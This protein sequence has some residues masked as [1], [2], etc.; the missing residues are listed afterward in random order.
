MLEWPP[1]RRLIAVRGELAAPGRPA[2]GFRPPQPPGRRRRRRTA[3]GGPTASRVR[4]GRRA[5]EGPGADPQAARARAARRPRAAGRRLDGV[6]DDDGRR[7]RPA[8]A[9][10]ARHAELGDR[11]PPRRAPRPPDRQHEPD[12]GQGGADRPRHEARDHRDRGQ[13]LLHQRRRRPP[14]HR[15][16]ALRGRRRPEGRPG[17]LDDRPAVR[18]E[19]AR[20]AGPPDAVREAA[21]G[22]A[23]VPHHAPLDQG[24][25]P[26]QLPQHDL[27]RQRRLR[28]RVRRPHLLR[29][30]A[31]GLREGP[32]APVRRP[33]RAG[34]GRDDRRRRRVPERL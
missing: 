7:L 29:P 18:Q 16:R 10:G 3:D 5:A 30:P 12:P 22:R 25:D 9:R 24:Q 20:G 15:P 28:H 19:L 14:R 26:P 23:R 8:G 34:R 2:Y 32:Q 27:L 13:A 6:R 33:A 1:G 31:P 17:R 11:R 21:R 4:H